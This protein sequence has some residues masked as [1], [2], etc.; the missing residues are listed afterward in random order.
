VR[1]LNRKD[2]Q[3]NL[4][5]ILYVQPDAPVEIIRASYRTVMQKLKAHPD[6]GGDE[7]NA[8][9]IN[10]AFAVLSDAQ[11]RRAYDAALFGKSDWKSL[12]KQSPMQRRRAYPT[13]PNWHEFRPLKI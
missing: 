10:K 8:A 3:R 1:P 7:W 6:L 9:I 5:R 12:G 4:Y 2:N 13:D 11:K